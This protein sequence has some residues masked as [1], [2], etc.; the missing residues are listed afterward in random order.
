MLTTVS[1]GPHQPVPGSGR[2][3]RNVADPDR[4]CTTGGP[5]P[6]NNRPATSVLLVAY[7]A[8]RETAVQTLQFISDDWNPSQTGTELGMM[9][10]ATPEAYTPINP[11]TPTESGGPDLWRPY[12][13]G[14]SVLAARALRVSG[15]QGADSTPKSPHPAVRRSPGEPGVV[16][17]DPQP[18]ELRPS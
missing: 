2:P 18:L 4:Q 12:P 15:P 17:G 5:S 10:A 7:S 9:A 11:T 13:A 6:S 8:H 1:T 16:G 3:R 14:T